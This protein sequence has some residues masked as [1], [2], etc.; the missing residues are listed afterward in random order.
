MEFMPAGRVLLA[1]A[2]WFGV[3]LKGMKE[4]AMR[5]LFP[6]RM[7]FVHYSW[8]LLP[9]ICPCDIHFCEYL[10]ERRVRKR[11]IFHF[12]TGGHHVVGRCNRKHAL[13][14]DIVAITASPSEHASYVRQ[15]IR[16][17]SIGSRY[18]VL[19][20]DIYNLNAACMPTFDLI[21]LFHLC[22]FVE[23]PSARRQLDDAGVLDLFLSKAT[24]RG[25]LLFYSRSA[26]SLETRPLI[27]RAV[28]N[29]RMCFEEQYKS[30]LVY[31]ATPA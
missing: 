14:N 23:L 12:G 2:Y 13:E 28:A 15:I 4:R 18:K 25:R 1:R 20:A 24:P 17:P 29:G 26:G 5:T 21:T 16:E 10:K 22:E 19:F 31:R 9:Q 7:H 3:R 8:P 30:L 27:D 11:A 6:S